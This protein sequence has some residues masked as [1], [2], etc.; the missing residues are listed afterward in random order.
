M[1][2]VAF[3]SLTPPDLCA[4]CVRDGNRDA[5]RQTELIRISGHPLP[6]NK[7]VHGWDNISRFRFR[8]IPTNAISI[9]EVATFSLMGFPFRT[10]SFPPPTCLAPPHPR[11]WL[12][13]AQ[14]VSFSENA[15]TS[16]TYPKRLSPISV[17]NSTTAVV[18]AR[19]VAVRSGIV[20][21]SD[22]LLFFLAEKL[23][24]G[25][26]CPGVESRYFLRTT[27]QSPTTSKAKSLADCLPLV[28]SHSAS[29]NAWYIR[30]AADNW[31]L[32]EAAQPALPKTLTRSATRWTRH[33]KEDTR[34]TLASAP[35]RPSCSPVM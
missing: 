31:A 12:A 8:P 28:P 30:N 22:S 19:P 3:T 35:T 32:S 6:P 18:A 27:G 5:G 25:S 10:K 21:S 16:P 20:S 7:R 23:T 11:H 33:I 26:L 24:L 29:D 17:I 15:L 13:L 14:L 4:W 9:R 1:R 2:F 34:W